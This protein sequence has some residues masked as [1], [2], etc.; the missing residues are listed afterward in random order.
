M[1][2][3]KKAID[4]IN[5]MDIDLPLSKEEENART[6]KSVIKSIN[7][8]KEQKRF[9]GKRVFATALAAV[10]VFVL[11][12]YAVAAIVESTMDISIPD[13]IAAWFNDGLETKY[14]VNYTL[15]PKIISDTAQKEIDSVND[16]GGKS[17]TSIRDAEQYL[18][19]SFLKNP[20]LKPPLYLDNDTNT[21][22]SY[23]DSKNEHMGLIMTSYQYKDYEKVSIDCNMSF[24]VDKP[25]KGS[26]HYLWQD[27]ADK[28]KITAY[29]SKKNGIDAKISELEPNN[30]IDI[31]IHFIY[32]NIAYNIKIINFDGLDNETLAK[33]I[34]DSFAIE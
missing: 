1:K 7:E 27:T 17:F 8:N 32:D 18:G 24:A 16:T 26:H 3:N 5:N 9:V 13:K 21:I 23:N 4:I 29:V 14:A 2:N 34:I 30:N 15:L 25:Q 22:L 12:F 20:T 31:S 6:Y 19:L 11:S 33:D 28:A 10:L